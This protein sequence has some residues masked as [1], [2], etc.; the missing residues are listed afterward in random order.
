MKVATV[1]RDAAGDHPAEP[2]HRAP[3][4]A[5]RATPRPHRAELRPALSDV[6]FDELG[7]RAPDHHLGDRGR[8]LRRA[9]SGGSSAGIG[10][11]LERERP[12]RVLVLGDTNS[13]L[14]ALVAKRL[15]I[16]VFHME[17]GNRCYDDRVPEEVNRRIIDHAA[18]CCCPT[19][20]AAGEN[21][22]REGIDPRRVFVTGNPIKEVLDAL[23]RRGSTASTALADLG[24]EPD[25]LLA[26]HAAP[27]G[28]RRRRRPAARAR[29]RG[30]RR[31]RRS[32]ACRSSS[33]C[34]RARA[35]GSS[36]SASTRPGR[37]GRAS[38]SASST[39]S[40]SS[41]SARCVL[42]DS[43]TVQEECCIL[44]VPDGHDPRRHRA[45]R[46]ARVR[47]QRPQRRRRRRRRAGA[48]G[49]PSSARPTGGSR[50]S[51]RRQP[52]AARSA[53]S[54]PA[55]CPPL[56]LAPRPGQGGPRRGRDPDRRR[57]RR[58]PRGRDLP[59][60]A[61]PH[62]PVLRRRRGARQLAGRVAVFGTLPRV[63]L[64]MLFVVSGFVLFLPTA[65]RGGRFG[66]VGDYALRRAAR[67]LPAYWLSLL[68]AI[69]L[70]AVLPLGPGVARDRRIAPARD[71]APDARDAV[72][73]GLRARLR[74][75]SPRSGRSRS[76]RSSTSCCR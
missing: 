49:S 65:A 46:D 10:A 17:A 31:R 52:S 27:P 33:A 16:P 42:T 19:P 12:D 76:R 34:T 57:L 45:A 36:A 47:Q 44:R 7:V 6:F 71:D 13:A 73:R 2:R 37:C 25:E 35:S 21:L 41:A 38:R 66:D 53:P 32:S 54:S 26:A 40:R 18:T 22:L 23:R 55:R 28:E 4:R 5:L 43:G 3:R 20:S 69:V 24:L 56:E 58:L 68:V 63:P 61:L 1:A 30:R 72:R 60:R 74:A 62:L 11:V 14:S 51:T 15:G 70:L 50:P 39:S 59:G 75:S 48:A 67:I 29:R 8:G 9:A 64:V